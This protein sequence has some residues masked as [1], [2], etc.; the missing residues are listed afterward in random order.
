MD[1]KH[2]TIV[3][4][5]NSATPLDFGPGPPH[6]HLESNGINIVLQQRG[7]EMQAGMRAS[8]QLMTLG[9]QL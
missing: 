4:V 9:K 8:R 6:L 7:T 2:M 1:V 3:Q 5:I